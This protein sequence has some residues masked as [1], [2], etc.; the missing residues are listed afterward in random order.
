[1]VDTGYHTRSSS[2]LAVPSI[3]MKIAKFPNNFVVSPL[4]VLTIV[5]EGVSLSAKR[6]AVRSPAKDTDAPGSKRALYV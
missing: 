4:I 5:L 2:L 6:C 3:S 1:M